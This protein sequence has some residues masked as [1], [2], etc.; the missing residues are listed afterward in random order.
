MNAVRG[1]RDPA[2]DI[3]LAADVVVPDPVR[4]VVVFAHGCGSSRHSSRNQY[5]AHQL[6]AAGFATVLAELLTI[7]EERIDARTGALRFDIG[8]LATRVTAL[9]DWLTAHQP[10]AGLDVGLFAPLGR[11]GRV[12]R[13]SPRPGRRRAVGGSPAHPP[14]RRWA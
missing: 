13:W 3:G 6:Q 1:S 8:L 10:T 11:C 12:S 5:V 4:G 2:G 7:R 14:D 9:T